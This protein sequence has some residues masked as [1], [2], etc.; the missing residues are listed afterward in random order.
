MNGTAFDDDGALV[1]SVPFPFHE[2]DPDISGKSPEEMSAIQANLSEI[3]AT[4]RAE[5]WRDA[6]AEMRPAVTRSLLLAL[7]GGHRE[8]SALLSRIASAMWQAGI[9]SLQ[10]ASKMAGKSTRLIRLTAEKITL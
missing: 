7:A 8:P 2:L 5:A 6:E 3:V 4:I 9:I 10:D 1:P